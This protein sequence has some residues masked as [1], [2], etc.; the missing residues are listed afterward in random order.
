MFRN[1]TP[2]RSHVRDDSRRSFSEFCFVDADSDHEIRLFQCQV[3]DVACYDCRSES[4]LDPG[5]NL[6]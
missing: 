5:A 3:P 1:Q 6:Q 4:H 2:W